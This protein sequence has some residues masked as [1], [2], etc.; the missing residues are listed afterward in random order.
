MV[1]IKSKKGST[2]RLAIWDLREKK[3]VING[4]QALERKADRVAKAMAI[5]DSV[6]KWN[7]GASA[8]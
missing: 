5:E 2:K 3:R 8:V 6:S 1:D 7:A 4:W